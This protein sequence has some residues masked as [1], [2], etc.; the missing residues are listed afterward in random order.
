MAAQV[1]EMQ[2][3]NPHEHAQWQQFLTSLGIPNFSAQEVEQIDVT[4]GLIEDDQLVGTGSLAGNVLKY[5]GVCHKNSQPGARFNQ[6][7]SA[8]VNRLFQEQIFHMMV[9][10]KAKYSLSFQHVGFKE[11]AHSH[12]AAVLENGAPDITDFVR[13]LP[14]ITNQAQRQVSAIVMNANPF[15]RGHRYLVEQA[16][17]VSDLVYVFVV[18]TDA[19]L[20]HTA[21]RVELVRQGTADLANV[22]VVSGGDYLVSAATFPAYFL[23]SAA[24]AIEAQ[25]TLDAR[26]FKNQLAPALNITTRFV[27]SE[28][29]S[30][31]TAIYNQVLQREL[32]PTVAVQVVPRTTV[33]KQPISARTV[34]QQIQSGHLTELNQLVPPTTVQF[35]KEHLTTLQT[36]IQEGMKIDGN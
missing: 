30:R 3:N 27:G 26:I 25:T 6:I 11:L 2:L 14:T 21:E 15:T 33:A 34:R 4:L 7:V 28:P 12:E 17:A 10:T 20:F 19:S 32:P 5:V 22:Q 35:I 1:V 36:R 8:L 29:T 18:A 23:D 13:Q 24:S 16:A 9:F 31:T